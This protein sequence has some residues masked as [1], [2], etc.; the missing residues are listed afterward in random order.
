MGKKSLGILV[1]ASALLLLPGGFA[2]TAVAQTVNGAFHGTVTD[3]SGAVIPGAIV[4]VKNLATGLVR[5]ASTD[6]AGFYA[7]TQ[8]PPGHYLVTATK[9]GF[10]TVRQPDVELLVNQDLAA[11]YTLQ[12]GLVTQQVQVNAAPAALETTGATI[13]QVIVSQQVVDLPLNGRQFTQMILLTPGAAPHEGGQQG[14]FIIPIGGGGISPNVNGQRGRQNNYTLDGGLNN[15]IY[16]DNWA[17]S[18]PPD[19]I[20]EFKVQSHIT[21]AAVGMSPGA[22]V[23]VATKTGSGQL[24]GDAWEF[25]RN[26]KLDAANFFDNVVVPSTKP[27]FRQN[28]FGFTLGGPVLLPTPKGL[29][30]GRRAKTYFFGYYEGFRSSQGFTSFNSVPTQQEL[31]GDFSD[32]LT[33][34]A[35]GTDPLGRTIF[36]GEIFNPYSTRQITAGQVDPVTGLVAQSTGQV[37]DPFA[38]NMIPQSMLNQQALTYL[39]A[40]YPVPNFGP[41]GNNFPNLAVSTSQVISDD[42]FGVKL[43]HTFSNNDTLFG[44]F[45]LTNPNEIQPNTLLLGTSTQLNNAK[46]I[47][48]G[49]T[50]LFSPTFLLT[51][52]YTYQYTHYFSGNTPAGL[53]LSEATNQIGFEPV[54]N[55]VPLVPQIGLAP[56]LGGTGQFSIPLGPIRSHIINVDVQKI[57]GSHTLTA[58]L[59]YYHIHSFDDGWGMT[60]SFDQFPTSSIIGP[61]NNQAQTGDGLASMLLNLPSG[62]SG[63]LGQTAANT[64]GLWQG[65][66]VQDK[67]QASRKLNLELGLRY[68]FVP[69]LNYANN[70]TSG[71][72][73]NC[74]CFLIS[75]PFGTL[76]PFAGVRKTYF[77]PQYRGF[78]PRFG[79]AY[80]LTPKSV[81]R[82]GFAMFDDHSNNLIQE[83]QDLRIPWPW[84]VD[85]NIIDLNRGVPNTFFSSPPS[86]ATFFPS[87]TQASQPFI[88]TGADNQNQIPTALE[89]NFGVQTEVLPSTTVDVTY[90]G[91]KTYH[92]QLDYTDNTVLPNQMGPGLF[93]GTSRTPYPQFG[94]FGYDDNIGYSNYN[95]LEVKVERRF[96]QGLTFLGSYTYSH[97]LDVNSGP[98]SESVQNPYDIYASN[99]GNC[100]Y[101][102]THLISFSSV[103]QLPFG[104]GK[105]YGGS[106]RRTTDA[107]LGGWDLGGIL[108]V[109][110]GSPFTA[111]VGFDNANT[112]AG[113]QQANIIGNPLP[114]GFEQN[115]FHWFDQTAFATPPP[116]TYGGAGKDNLR[117]PA[118]ADLDFTLTKDFKF[119]ESKSLEFRTE[120]FNILNRVNFANPGGNASP[121]YANLS[122]SSSTNLNSPTFMQILAAGPA[123]E[124][125]F[126]LKFIF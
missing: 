75:Q 31:K 81:L 54:K 126:S 123:R 92:L 28:Q 87:P 122:G 62:L 90:V 115:R 77:D 98:Y 74:A 101:D 37:R 111:A 73:N 113:Y 13:G 46:E 120:A 21:D 93:V 18:P 64:T 72:S 8:L 84:G 2:G 125:Q 50:H 51:L 30:D 47:S 99:Y 19:A 119:T 11:N 85:P 107:A 3:T 34:T 94:S 55:G 15:N 23:N 63:F 20:Q 25:L 79:V 61:G 36:K 124:I 6:A 59:M 110:S 105:H 100:D 121:G 96:S 78:Q 70:Q 69:P 4:E 14:S 76:F 29:Y 83:T 35:V 9:S 117:G 71:F 43:D 80:S 114:A 112:G 53:A 108:S 104:R 22:N 24:H 88:F 103:Y 45:Y 109:Q 52:H 97:C 57:S 1:W 66:Y 38:G 26:D 102:F 91:A 118:H 10:A 68:D 42:Q 67:W 17:I 41:G 116:F 89:W 33:S 95:A 49:Y 32:L 16:L 60:Q 86:A 106:W 58:G 7:I 40:F 56:R 12:V 48:T 44:G 39:H 82:G 5:R 27:P 65:Y